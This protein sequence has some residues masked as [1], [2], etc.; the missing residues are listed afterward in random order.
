MVEGKLSGYES[1]LH[2]TKYYIEFN[3]APDAKSIQT[4]TVSLDSEVVTDRKA[5]MDVSLSLHPLYANLEKY[6]LS[7]PSRKIDDQESTSKH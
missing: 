6:V 7:N 4:I 5:L 1:D 2:M 3:V